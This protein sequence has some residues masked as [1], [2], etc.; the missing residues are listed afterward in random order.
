MTQRLPA[1]TGWGHYLPDKVVTNKDLE[2]LVDT[3]ADWIKTRTGIAQRRQAHIDEATSSMCIIAARRALARARLA[4]KDLD[5]VI[6]ATT[7][8][9]FLLPATACIIQ[10]KIAAVRAGAFDINTACTGFLNGLIVAAQFIQ[11]GTCRRVLVVA[12]ETLTRFIN[13]QDRNSAVL[14]GDGAGAAVLEA[15]DQDGGILGSV[16]GCRGDVDHLLSIEGG[17]AARPAT[18]NTVS[19]GDHFIRMRGK[20]VFKVAVRSMNQAARETLARAKLTPD[21]I[22]KV[23][24][25]QANLRIMEA[26]QE[27]LGLPLDKMYVN[28][29]RYGN[30]G[31]SSVAIALSEFADIDP[32][33]PGDHL[34]LVAFGGGL[35][36]AS[37]VIR[38]ANVDAVIAQREARLTGAAKAAALI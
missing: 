32:L 22:R 9:D 30:T 10:E 34:L 5:L 3:T 1:V 7:T 2:V 15:S 24:P 33:Q 26:T 6:C 36:W 20:D 38:W 8:P 21:D 37:V 28:V 31:A 23:I 14:F 12:G 11:A 19:S 17:G 13:W 16:L 18:H 35:T 4:A 27:M 29:D 25:H